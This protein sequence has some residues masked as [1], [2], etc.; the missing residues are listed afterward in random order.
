MQFL[1]W[2]NDSYSAI[3][4]Q[5]ELMNPLPTVGCTCFLLL[6]EEKH[7][8]LHYMLASFTEAAALVASNKD[9]L[10]PSG[11]DSR[12]PSR[13]PLPEWLCGDHCV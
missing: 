13:G 9:Q 5:I 4:G 2:L 12:A 6:L 7:H 8:M 3:H 11:C 1:M 10:N